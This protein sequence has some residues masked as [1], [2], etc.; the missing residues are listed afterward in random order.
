M[1]KLLQCNQ[2]TE[3]GKT[4]KNKNI[5]QHIYNTR[6]PSQKS[7]KAFLIYLALQSNKYILV[8]L[9]VVE[10]G[11]IKGSA[12]KKVTM[13]MLNLLMKFYK[14]FSNYTMWRHWPHYTEIKCKAWLSLF[15]CVIGIRQGYALYPLR[16]LGSFLSI[17]N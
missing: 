13:C 1:V 9:H 14:V 17:F 15:K 16:V 4:K 3:N 10:G 12:T 2:I 6:H 5:K 11:N 8:I 7:L